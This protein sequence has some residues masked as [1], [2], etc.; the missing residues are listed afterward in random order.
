M[1]HSV[2][3]SVRPVSAVLAAAALAFG[4]SV[5]A[6]AAGPSDFSQSS[7]GQASAGLDAPVS[8][9][10]TQAPIAANDADWVP[11]L[12]EYVLAYLRTSGFAQLSQPFASKAE[13]EAGRDRNALDAPWLARTD[14]FTAR[15]KY[16]YYSHAVVD[17]KKVQEELDLF[18][19][20][21][22]LRPDFKAVRDRIRE[23]RGWNDAC[24]T[25]NAKK[26]LDKELVAYFAK[27]DALPD[28][29]Q[30][31]SEVTARLDT[32]TKERFEGNKVSSNPLKLCSSEYVLARLEAK[33]GLIARDLARSG[34]PVAASTS[35]DDAL[36]DLT[37]A[38]ADPSA[39]SQTTGTGQTSD[40]QQVQDL[41]KD[42]FNSL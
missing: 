18:G 23:T 40:D 7:S 33:R 19:V 32:K 2:V 15:G 31:L 21:A 38:P 11:E 1:P 27:V 3:R 17:T 9:T 20:K 5:P 35:A 29:R 13:C 39:N 30:R 37:S 42:L 26:S 4:Q 28:L 34:L 25:R 41:F 6:L 22:G 10:G 36:P 16:R 8:G 24:V 14:C 12:S